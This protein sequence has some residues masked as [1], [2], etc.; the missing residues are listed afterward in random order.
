[1]STLIMS[2]MQALSPHPKGFWLQKGPIFQGHP[3]S[4]SFGC[5]SPLCLQRLAQEKRGGSN[6]GQNPDILSP[7]SDEGIC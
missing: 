3:S 6:L 2:G 7:L 4:L 1:M 5:N